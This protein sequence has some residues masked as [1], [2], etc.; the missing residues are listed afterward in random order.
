MLRDRQAETDAPGGTGARPRPPPRSP[1]RPRRSGPTTT[2]TDSSLGR[3]SRY[4]QQRRSGDQ[5]LSA[6][7]ATDQLVVEASLAPSESAAP[8]AG[9]PRVYQSYF[10]ANSD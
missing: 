10:M 6:R 3:F 4:Q 7:S 8:P 9:D 2:P 5:R 1:A